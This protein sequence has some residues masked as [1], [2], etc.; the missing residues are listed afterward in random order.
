M[1]DM[2]AISRAWEGKISSI[3]ICEDHGVVGAVTPTCRSLEKEKKVP[4]ILAPPQIKI[5]KFRYF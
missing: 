1:R 4:A 5:S 3:T 2:G